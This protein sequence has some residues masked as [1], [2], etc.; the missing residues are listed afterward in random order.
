MKL[1]KP[2]WTWIIENLANVFSL[3]GLVATIYF[4]ITVPRWINEYK[5]EKVRNAQNE[6]IQS[7][8]EFVYSDSTISI[9]ELNSIVHAKEISI[10]QKIP[11]N[12]IDILEIAEGSFMEDKFLPL[13]KRQELIK[14]IES[15]KRFMRPDETGSN[16]LQRS[17]SKLSGWLEWLS[18][19]I[20]I[21]AVVLGLVSAFIKYQLNKDKEEEIKNEKKDISLTK[22]HRQ[23]AF[24]FV[25]K[26]GE[27]MKN[28]V[29]MIRTNVGD[30]GIDF[31]FKHKGEMF[32]V[33]V[34]YLTRSKVGLNSYSQLANYV[35]N[36][37]GQA[38]LIY[39]TE[40]TPLVEKEIENFNNENKNMKIRAIKVPEAEDFKESIDLLLTK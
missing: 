25:E 21:L 35:Q 9:L 33:E 30:S 5:I 1:L 29:E 6:I 16:E 4:G 12:L 36:K 17:K 13:L 39:N 22:N 14:E 18:I 38:W 10:N 26:I 3:L 40:L 2:V 24:E 7:V 37:N 23:Y 31:Q 32:Y 28:H 27:I 11:L 34:K 20:S 19:I 15:I 8:K